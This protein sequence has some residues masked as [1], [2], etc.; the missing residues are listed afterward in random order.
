MRPRYKQQSQQL[1]QAMLAKK[2]TWSRN[3]ATLQEWAEQFE[4]LEQ[5]VG[6]R[7]RIQKVLDWYCKFGCGALFVPLIGTA[8]T[9]REK[10]QQLEGAME[11]LQGQ[12]L[13]YFDDVVQYDIQ[14][15]KTGSKA[16]RECSRVMQR[17]QQQ[18]EYID[19]LANG[20]TKLPKAK[21]SRNGQASNGK[22]HIELKDYVLASREFLWQ[23]I[24]ANPAAEAEWHRRIR[25]SRKVQKFID[26]V[27]S[28]F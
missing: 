3:A 16:Q 24:V 10:F 8:E 4:Q 12:Q 28:E 22:L 1:Y 15:R 27:D 17:V 18:I 19:D 14:E 6:S 20:R 13:R 5:E 25:R 23:L 7:K 21:P 2:Q 11:R 26:K 9:F